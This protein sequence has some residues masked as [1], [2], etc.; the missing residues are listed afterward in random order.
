MK[1]VAPD[2]TVICEEEGNGFDC[3]AFEALPQFG[4]ASSYRDLVGLNH[5]RNRWYDARL[6][7]F[8]THDPLGYVDGYNLYAYAAMD[9]INFW[10]PYGLKTQQLADSAFVND[11]SPVK[12]E[13]DGPCFDTS[14]SD[15]FGV[16]GGAR[17]A[18]EGIERGAQEVGD[19]NR[20]MT[21][22]VKANAHR[23]FRNQRG[24]NAAG[25]GA[26]FVLADVWSQLTPQSKDDVL[27]EL[28]TLGAGR[29]LDA[30][31]TLG[32][33]RNVRLPTSSPGERHL[34]SNAEDFLDNGVDVRH[35]DTATAIGNDFAVQINFERSTNLAPEYFDI[36]V[37]GKM[38]DGGAGFIT[39]DG[40]FTHAQQISDAVVRNPAFSGQDVRL[41]SCFGAC[42]PAQEVANILQTN[43]EAV[44]FRTWLD[45]NGKQGTE[46]PTVP[47]VFQPQ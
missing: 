31:E 3:A 33:L 15:V 23:Q 19:A 38:R 42:G 7:Q 10:D 18:A 1:H 6:N 20:R 37:H 45:A 26:A 4:F 2:G 9:P 40:W 17:G 13:C 34:L 12:Q 28:S 5:M 30:A 22:R 16:V 25:P 32:R 39:G 27:L 36:I 47:Q 35:S 8:L 14:E 21:N 11:D 24:I 44:P 41:L 46:F 29:V 43:V